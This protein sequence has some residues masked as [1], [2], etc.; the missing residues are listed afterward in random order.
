MYLSLNGEDPI[1]MIAEFRQPINPSDIYK[2]LVAG[3]FYNDD[4]YARHS[5][6][7]SNFPME[8]GTHKVELFYSTMVAD[9]DVLGHVYT[10]LDTLYNLQ[11]HKVGQRRLGGF[12]EETLPYGKSEEAQKGEPDSLHIKGTFEIPW[13]RKLEKDFTE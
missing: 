7:L 2:P 8:L 6:T 12:F 1:E 13:S 3:T 10:N 5:T 4:G 9:G 11:I